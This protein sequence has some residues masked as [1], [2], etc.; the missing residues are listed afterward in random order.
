MVI[1]KLLISS[2]NV[3]FQKI[4]ISP[5]EGIGN[6]SGGC[7]R[8]RNFWRRGEDVVLMNF[9]SRSISVFLLEPANQHLAYCGSPPAFSRRSNPPEEAKRWL[10]DLNRPAFVEF[11]WS[12]SLAPIILR[13]LYYFV[14]L[15]SIFL[16]TVGGMKLKF[17]EEIKKKLVYQDPLPFRWD[18]QYFCVNSSLKWRR[19]QLTGAKLQA[20]S[21]FLVLAIA[22][23]K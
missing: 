11:L 2:Y 16:E 3:W 21:P 15:A 6:S 8:P 19:L 17:S 10:V 1:L 13:K 18:F 23:Q 7:R 12:P 14:T 9:F 20:L 5:M 4:S 22:G